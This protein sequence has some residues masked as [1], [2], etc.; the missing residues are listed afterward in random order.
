MIDREQLVEKIRTSGLKKEFIAAKIG[1]SLNSL[2]NKI[3]GR[4]KFIINE[5]FKLKILLNLSDEEFNSIF[6]PSLSTDCKQE[7]DYEN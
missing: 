2:N 6:L 3:S 7:I 5:A 1:M 4:T